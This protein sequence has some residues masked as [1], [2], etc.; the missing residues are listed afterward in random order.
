VLLALLIIVLVVLGVMLS[1]YGDCC[2]LR[3]E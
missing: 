2:D 3:R 1:G